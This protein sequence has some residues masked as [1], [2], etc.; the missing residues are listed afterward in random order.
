VPAPGGVTLRIHTVRIGC[1]DP[2]NGRTNKATTAAAEFPFASTSL[3]ITI[4]IVSAAGKAQVNASHW[5]CKAR[6]NLRCCW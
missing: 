1:A 2:A 6:V 5:F 4:S 3:R